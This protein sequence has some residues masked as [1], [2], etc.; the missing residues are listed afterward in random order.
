MALTRYLIKLNVVRQFHVPCVNTEYL[1]STSGVWYTNVNLAVKTAKSSQG[2]V[3]AVGEK[4]GMD[5]NINSMAQQLYM[6]K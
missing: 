4:R 2:T 1:Q 5:K 3:N 6:P